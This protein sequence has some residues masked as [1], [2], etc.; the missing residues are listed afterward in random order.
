[1][2]GRRGRHAKASAEAPQVP[3][4]GEVLRDFRG[5]TRS[6]PGFCAALR[7][8]GLLA[9]GVVLLLVLAAGQARADGPN[10]AG[11]VVRFDDEHVY[12]ACI[13]FSEESLTG[14]EVLQRSGLNIG[15]GF[16]G[17]AVCRIEELGCEGDN[18]FCQCTGADCRY[19]AY[20]RR[21]PDGTWKYSQV[22]AGDAIVRDGDVE[23]WSWGPGVQAPPPA[24]SLDEICAVQGT[25]PPTPA[26]L[27][28]PATS[29]PVSTAPHSEVP[30]VTSSPA[31][32]TPTE[33]TAPSAPA[34]GS[35]IP[36]SY[37]VFA[38][39]VLALIGVLAVLGR[40]RAPRR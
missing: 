34:R 32:P 12:T 20:F 30:P 26:P 13:A 24:I 23:G 10:R 4:R 7:R 25:F 9:L 21:G 19:W 16:G 15:R 18:C 6:Q 29:T 35:G 17:G 31:V 28:S 38:L 1:V 40:G 39:L 36:A 14:L 33:A 22:G 27:N 11:L 37:G 3:A 2:S 8:G 5:L